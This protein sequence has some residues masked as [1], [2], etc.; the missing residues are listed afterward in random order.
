[1][2]ESDI[3]IATPVKSCQEAQE[4]NRVM[5]ALLLGATIPKGKENGESSNFAI[6]YVLATDNF[7]FA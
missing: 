4:P 6:S 3:K 5:I 1:M 2:L 7:S